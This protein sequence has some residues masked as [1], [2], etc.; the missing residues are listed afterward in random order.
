MTA[1]WWR[2]ATLE[3]AAKFQ[4]VYVHYR[5]VFY[6]VWLGGVGTDIET[7]EPRGSLDIGEVLG[8]RS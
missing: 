4:E 6:A 8:L 3:A 5:G 7:T 2:A 1:S